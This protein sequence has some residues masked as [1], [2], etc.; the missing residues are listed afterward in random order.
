MNTPLVSIGI[1]TFNRAESLRIAI[2]SVIKQDYKNIE[3]VICD[4]GSTDATESICRSYSKSQ[5]NINYYRSVNN[6]GALKN[7]QSA[8][9]KCNGEYFMWLADDDF[10]DTN[11][12]TECAKILM[13]DDE[14]AVV[15]GCALFFGGKNDTNGYNFSIVS[16][17]ALI[18]MC[19]YYWGVYDNSIFYGLMRSEIAKKNNLKPS[20]VS[21]WL[22]IA[23]MA[24][25]GKILTTEQTV[26]HRQSGGASMSLAKMVEMMGISKIN[27]YFSG[28]ST[29]VSCVK[30][31]LGENKIYNQDPLIRRLIYSLVIFCVILIRHG[32]L[33]TVLR[34]LSRILKV[35]LG[36][37]TFEKFKLNIKSQVF[38]SSYIITPKEITK[39]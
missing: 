22:F 38:K 16:K 12:V 17:N 8:I 35:L 18:R 24:F 2:E 10:I 14:M 37:N 5:N 21:D 20:M 25:Q 32:I 26:I 15:G 28:F 27:I 30:D 19:S 9:E 4:N 34:L 11:Y 36:H 13:T 31:I 39:F 3:I 1:P 33:N 29:A 7:F 6:Q 23:G